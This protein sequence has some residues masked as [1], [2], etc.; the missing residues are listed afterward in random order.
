M[1]ILFLVIVGLTALSYISAKERDV[2]WF[3]LRT[4]R[5][6]GKQQYLWEQHARKI[7]KQLAA[8]RAALEKKRANRPTNFWE[9]NALTRDE[10]ASERLIEHISQM[11]P[12]QTANWCVEKAIYDI[13]RDRMA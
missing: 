4:S 3:S 8:E 11:N 1:W 5:R 10:A 9:L 12:G 7:D 2:P 6:V 13:H